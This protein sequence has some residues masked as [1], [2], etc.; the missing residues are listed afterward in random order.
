MGGFGVL[1]NGV[2]VLLTLALLVFGFSVRLTVFA[3]G[4]GEMKP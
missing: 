1:L 3:T 4:L 2:V